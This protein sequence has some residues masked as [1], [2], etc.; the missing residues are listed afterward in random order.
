VRAGKGAEQIHV[1]NT[2]LPEARAITK[3]SGGATDPIWSSDEKLILF[4]SQSFPE[5]KDQKCNQQKENQK[6]N[7]VSAKAY[8]ELLYRHWNHYEDGRISHLFVVAS[9]GSGP[10]RDITPGKHAVPPSYLNRSPGFDFVNNDTIVFAKNVEE[11]GALSTNHDIFLKPIS[12]N[13]S[14]K[15]TQNKA[16]DAR[17]VTSPNQKFIAYFSYERP[18]FEADRSVLTILE[19]S[20]GKIRH[21]SQSID[22]SLT[23]FAWWPDNQGLYFVAHQK[24]HRVLG[25]VRLSDSKPEILVSDRSIRALSVDQQNRVYFS[26]SSLNTPPEIFRYEPKSRVLKQL[27]HVNKESTDKLHLG[28]IK[29]E[30]V[31]DEKNSVHGFVVLP[32][33]FNPVRRYPMVVLIHGGPQGAWTNSWHSR[34]NPQLFAAQGYIVAMPN[35]RGSRGYGQKF[36]DAVTQNWGGG[37]FKDI[38]QFT[39]HIAKQKYVDQDQIC[40]AGASYGGYMVNWIAS[41]TTRFKCLISHAGLYNLESFWGDTEELWFPEWEFGGPPWTHKENYRKWSP[42]EFIQNAK[43]PTLVIHGQ[44]DYRVDLSHGL[45]MFTA[46]RRQNILS[47]LVYFPDEGHWIKKPKNVVYWY[48]E[49]LGWLNKFLD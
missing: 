11:K 3:L 49:M 34:W 17:P 13:E 2:G 47:R 45:S 16:W 5:C 48:D 9:D 25:Q 35:P 19:I 39:E 37:P 7:H 46:L 4:K 31:A 30:V 38:M 27:S 41:Q 10:A 26:A 20:T 40:A 21:L 43:T 33:G 42:S 36:T 32:P 29:E 28:K 1:L 8:D 22:A 12:K 15:L 18:G 14:K 24:G 6:K 44:L 23:E